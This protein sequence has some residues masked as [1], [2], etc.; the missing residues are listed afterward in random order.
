MNSMK[1]AFQKVIPSHGIHEIMPMCR[2]VAGNAEIIENSQILD[3]TPCTV[4]SG[5][6]DE[7]P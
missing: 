6:G 2:K 3:N 4:T 7:I 1:N 5:I